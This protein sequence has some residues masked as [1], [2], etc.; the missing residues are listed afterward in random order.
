VWLCPRPRLMILLDNDAE[1][2]WRRKPEFPL[3]LIEGALAR[4]RQA[5]RSCG[6]TVIR[7]DL[8]LEQLVDSF[9]ERHWRDLVRWRRDG[10][11]F[12]RMR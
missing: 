3:A 11:P 6:M 4:Y 12:P 2:I 8:P 5:A 10:L 1:T 9:I 7:T